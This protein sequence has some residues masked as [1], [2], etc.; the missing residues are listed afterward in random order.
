MRTE[1]IVKYY[2]FKGFSVLC[3]NWR[4]M[5]DWIYFSKNMFCLWGCN[6]SELNGSTLTDNEYYSQL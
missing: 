4:N 5:T 1:E 3:R 6:S 2:T